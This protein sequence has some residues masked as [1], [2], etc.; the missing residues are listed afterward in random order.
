M[1]NTT[2]I[3]SFKPRS[4]IGWIWFVLFAA[5][6]AGLG[7]YVMIVLGGMS[8]GNLVILGI[9][10]ILAIGLLA[11]AL[12][13]PSMRYEL[14]SDRL[15][16]RYGP[17]I[18]YH[19]PFNEIRGIRTKNMSWTIM[20]SVRFPGIALFEVPYGGEGNIKMCSS[21]AVKNV[22][23]IDTVNGKFGVTPAEEKDFIEA[24]QARIKL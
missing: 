2:L 11:L 4:S 10:A 24:L 7:V 14:Y 12:W 21:A 17:V 23:L 18:N 15:I 16:L 20:S 13:F 6:V 19:I 8:G 22:L 9:A 5:L 1:E 3:K